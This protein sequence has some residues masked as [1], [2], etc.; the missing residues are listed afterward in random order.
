M[1]KAD[2]FV[3]G[4]GDSIHLDDRQG[5]LKSKYVGEGPSSNSHNVSESW[6]SPIVAP[7]GERKS[8][9]GRMKKLKK[10]YLCFMPF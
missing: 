2:C 9:A 4:E 8:A 6:D 1:M 3:P 10:K 7:C 5:G